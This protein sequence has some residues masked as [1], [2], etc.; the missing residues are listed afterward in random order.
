MKILFSNKKIFPVQLYTD[1]R[2]MGAR[3]KLVGN[4]SLIL[5]KFLRGLRI[6]L[7]L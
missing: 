4:F 7:N 3:K 1:S 5:M 6:K 2:M